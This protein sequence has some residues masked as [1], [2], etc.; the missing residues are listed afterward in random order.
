L[1]AAE[2]EYQRSERS[3]GAK[4]MAK[5]PGG[6]SSTPN[7]Q[8]G[9][10][11]KGFPLR[12][13]WLT[14]DWETIF[15]EQIALIKSDVVRARAEDRLVA[16]LSCPISSRGGGWSGTNVDIARHVERS[17]LE[18]WGEAFWILNPAQY[19]LES[20][21]GKGLINRHAEQFGIDLA[22][23]LKKSTPG[24][25][26]YMRMWTKVL[27]ED[28]T[29]N[30]GRNFDAFYFLGPRDVFSFFTQSQSLTLTAGIDAYF[31]RKFS[32]D[33]A[34]RDAFSI[35][36]IDWGH[37]TQASPGPEARKAWVKQRTDFLRFYGLRAS[38]NFSLGSHDEWEIFRLINELRR[39]KSA[40]PGM[41]D[42]DV[43]D[44]VA[45]YF[46][47]NQVDPSSSEA[48]VSRGYAV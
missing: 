19:Q 31:A 21:A 22:A 20:K 44:Q 9:E 28:G 13:T 42:G 40:Q 5:T 33:A 35:P 48:K 12:F 27:V 2:S 36:N 14:G 23:L 43:G 29:G 7:T 10:P 37:A 34:F 47:G 1:G 8:T 25:G 17:L 46:D 24:G 30:L 15:D 3:E 41:L 26:D 4:I 11:V 18:R 39:K 38:A 6:S 16:Y 32:T 45:G